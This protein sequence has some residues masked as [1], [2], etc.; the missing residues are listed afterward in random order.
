[1][2]QRWIPFLVCLFCLQSSAYIE[3]IA[4]H[5]MKDLFQEMS[6][7]GQLHGHA[8]FVDVFSSL[9]IFKLDEKGMNFV[10]KIQLLSWGEYGKKLLR[11]LAG[12]I[13]GVTRELTLL[14]S[15]HTAIIRDAGHPNRL[16]KLDPTEWTLTCVQFPE[17]IIQLAK[18]G[19]AILACFANGKWH[20]LDPDTLQP[21]FDVIDLPQ[22]VSQ[23]KKT[24]FAQVGDYFVYV[25]QDKPDQ[26]SFVFSGQKTAAYQLNNSIHSLIPVASDRLIAILENGWGYDTVLLQIDQDALIELERVFVE[27]PDIIHFQNPDP[28]LSGLYIS[29]KKEIL[30]YVNKN[31][32]RTYAVSQP[33]DSLF[34]KYVVLE[35]DAKGRPLFSAQRASNHVWLSL[36]K[37]ALFLRRN[38][39]Q[40]W[41]VFEYV[42]RTENGVELCSKNLDVPVSVT[43]RVHWMHYEKYIY[44]V[45]WTRKQVHVFLNPALVQLEN[46]NEQPQDLYFFNSNDLD[47]RLNW[48]EV[49]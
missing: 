38:W 19:D 9:Y 32:A 45:N 25:Q 26:L 3:P 5:P 17:T 11:D 42:C 29:G 44:H 12:E 13:F 27:S 34:E 4:W 46:A 2:I 22:M 47:A 23:Q 14:S 15:E 20:F 37:G 36:E 6:Y 1:M 39:L 18:A 24:S 10:K 48:N 31:N 43:D 28:Y 21:S 41:W 16:W 33:L 49:P 7:V 35:N 40:T 8:L 30:L